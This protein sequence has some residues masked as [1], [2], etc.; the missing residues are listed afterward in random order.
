MTFALVATWLI[1]SVIPP[2]T[3]HQ[4]EIPQGRLTHHTHFGDDTHREISHSGVDLRGS[5]PRT[6]ADEAWHLHFVFLGVGVTLPDDS[7]SNDDRQ[8]GDGDL[9]YLR[10]NLEVS[11]SIASSNAA[12]FSSPLAVAGQFESA[13]SSQTEFGT[14]PQVVS[15]PLCDRARQE[16][17]GVLRV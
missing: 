5:L 6:H 16:R 10:V 2:G 15:S 14:L 11:V 8:L 3:R 4:H 7:R 9:P 1:G 17:S 12:I 13:G